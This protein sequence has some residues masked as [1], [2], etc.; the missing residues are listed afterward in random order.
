MKSISGNK[1]YVVQGNLQPIELWSYIFPREHLS[2]VAKSLNMSSTM[3]Q[4]DAP[5]HAP[6]RTGALSLLR[7][8]LGLKKIPNFQEEKHLIPFHINNMQIL[9]LG[10]KEDADAEDHEAL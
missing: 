3:G 1:K 2:I 9:G 6:Y 8:S 5:L 10:I 7:N 4:K